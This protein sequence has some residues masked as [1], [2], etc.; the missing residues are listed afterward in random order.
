VVGG[1][2][3]DSVYGGA[4]DDAIGG[5]DGN[6]RVFGGF[7][8]DRV[9][10]DA[11]ND[12]VTGDD[13]D[14]FVVGGAGNDAVYG[15]TGND[16][17]GGDDGDDYVVGGSGADLLYGGSGSD[18]FIFTSAGGGA[19]SDTVFDYLAKVD[20]LD[21]SQIDAKIATGEHE[22]F[23]F[24]GG[25]AFS[26]LAGEIRAEV[27]NGGTSIYGDVNGDAVSDFS[28][29]MVGVVGIQASDLVL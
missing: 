27:A 13:G 14:D 22:Q 10:G 6:D 15:G 26:A 25:S 19:D 8:N 2:D 21:F 17:I 16:T 5:D 9:Y 28:V 4:G 20:R 29:F 7:G 18:T 11:G 23:L 24:I 3:N 12:E 1:S